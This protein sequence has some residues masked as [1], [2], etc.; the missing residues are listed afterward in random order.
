MSLSCN[1]WPQWLL[2]WFDKNRR[3]LPW[4]EDRTPYRVWVSE[5][6]LQ[7]TRVEAVRS[8]FENWMTL[9]P[10]P[11][12]L[13]NA[14]EEE[15]L[16][17]WQ[18]LGYYRRAKNL[19]IGVREVV[20]TYGGEVPRERK[21]LEALKGIGSYTAGAILSLAFNEREAAVDGN[22]LRIYARLYG[23]KE[24]I[25]GSVGKNKITRLVED[26]LPLQRPG[27]FNEALMDFGS[28]VCIPKS[29]KCE[30]C[31]LTKVCYAYQEGAMD[32]LPYREKKQ[33]V[34]SIPLL[35]GLIEWN[36]SYLLHRRPDTGLLASMWEFPMVETMAQDKA[37]LEKALAK[38]GI[39][40]EG[41]LTWED[42]AC[43]SLK[44]V[45]SHRKWHMTVFKGTLKLAQREALVLP[46]NYRWVEKKAFSELPWA[47]PHGKLTVFCQ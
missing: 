40:I 26:T 22:V 17:A 25:L 21:K 30:E 16:K 10:T 36:G 19:Q 41:S 9:F 1:N 39:P 34:P 27:D 43:T 29:P 44:H 3:D 33:V 14:S 7:Q 23:V 6:M 46:E 47:G 12:A 31:P 13:A 8:Y 18:G 15:V 2:N 5:I 20:T 24:N 4:R 32:T 42:N 28:A 35:V 11:E 45:F 38:E 37:L